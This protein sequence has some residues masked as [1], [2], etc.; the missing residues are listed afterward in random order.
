M[1][2]IDLLK[3]EGIPAKTTLGS[4][5]FVGV[6]AAVPVIV[7]AVMLSFYLL[8]NVNIDMKQG[9][10]V[11][12]EKIISESESYVK[13]TM[14]LEQQ[15]DLLAER[16]K[17]VSRCVD[18]FVQWSPIL[19]AMS[20]EMPGK[21]IM[22]QMQ[23]TSAAGRVTTGRKDKDPNKPVDIPMPKRTITFDIHGNEQG[24]FYT[25]VQD[26]Q[27]SLELSAAFNP[28]FEAQEFSVVTSSGDNAIEN[29]SM[30]F[31]SQT[32]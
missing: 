32:Q 20:E 25:T 15:R 9:D 29:Y 31:E 26:F 3:G 28:K 17:E 22:N 6:V 27:N 14:A 24:S 23:A 4:I 11:K 16:L 7:A 18:T 10:I 5:C 13:K 12:Y 30:R 2:K 21:M 1:H 8:N 19:I